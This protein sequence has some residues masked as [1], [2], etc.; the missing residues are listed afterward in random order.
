MMP[1]ELRSKLLE[2]RDQTHVTHWSL[3]PSGWHIALN[4]FYDEWLDLSDAFIE[5]WQGK[6]KTKIT[7][8]SSIY[9]SNDIDILKYLDDN[10]RQFLEKDIYQMIDKDKDQGLLSL[11]ADMQGLLDNTLDRMSRDSMKEIQ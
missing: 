6:H 1:T 4:T 11:I 7:G 10:V 8:I 2:I 3:I 9:V 5:Q